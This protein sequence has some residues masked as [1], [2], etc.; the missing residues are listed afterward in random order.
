MT[1]KKSNE[2]VYFVYTRGPTGPQAEKWFG[3][4][5]DGTGKFR[6]K[7]VGAPGSDLLFLEELSEEDSHLSLVQLKEKFPYKEK[8]SEQTTYQTS[9]GRKAQE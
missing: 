5:T 8:D 1:E 7:A 3:D 6:H 2:P 9:S 4:Q